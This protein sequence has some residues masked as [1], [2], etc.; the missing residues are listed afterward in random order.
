MRVY[1]LGTGSSGNALVVEADGARLLLEAGI[2]PRVAAVRMRSLGADL[3]PRGVDGVVITHHHNDHAAQLLPLCKALGAPESAAR[4]PMLHL[5]D[6]VDLP[7]IRHR[8]GVRRYR[9]GEAFDVR[10]LRVRT[11]AIAHDAPHVAVV[12][13]SSSHCLGFVTDVGSIT[14]KL[15]D[16]LA[17]C[18]TVLLESN[19]CP[20]LL[21]MSP[22]PMSLRR[23]IAGDLGHLSNAQAAALVARAVRSRAQRVVLCHLSEAN[24]EPELALRAVRD[25]S[26]DVFVEVLHH[27]QAR[28]LELPPRT[29]VSRFEQLP[30]FAAAK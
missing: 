21:D 14:S 10:G 13:E 16:F 30:L 9:A 29:P 19:Y 28:L 27:G 1:V 5:H 26:P 3:F 11:L 2:G 12:V 4:D 15:V 18:D 23:R 17:P 20:A 8:F 22:Y 25:A 24:N 6:G 7:V